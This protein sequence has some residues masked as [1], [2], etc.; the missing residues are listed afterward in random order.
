MSVSRAPR[1]A[2]AHK[3]PAQEELTEVLDIE[4]QVGRTGALTPVARLEPVFV[5]GVTVSNATLHNID[6]LNRKDVRV[7]DT[8]IVR[9]AGD[10]IPE[11]VSVITARRPEGTKKVRL[12]RICP[13]CKSAVEREDG[14]AV[15][16]CTGGLFCSAQR[17][18][19]LK[20]FV[21]RKAMDIDGLGSKVIEQLVAADRVKTPADIYALDEDELASMERMGEKS[22]ANLL[23]GCRSS[24][25][26]QSLYFG[27]TDGNATYRSGG[28]L[29]APRFLA[30]YSAKRCCL[31]ISR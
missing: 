30:R 25:G 15:A 26:S 22:A 27:S 20:H 19:S 14:E 7:G 2:I 3:F 31:V 10:V 18:E 24:A 4:F 28:D 21:S 8:V 11:G 9:R 6:E 23:N 1:W 13:I 29:Q 5:G 16:R 12:P 17:V